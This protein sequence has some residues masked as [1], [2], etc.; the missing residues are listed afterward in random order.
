MRNMR[1][2]VVNAFSVAWTAVVVSAAATGP[3]REYILDRRRSGRDV[4]LPL[5]AAAR[6]DSGSR[7]VEQTS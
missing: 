2:N 6:L 7:F 4:P 5:R 1:E 3:A